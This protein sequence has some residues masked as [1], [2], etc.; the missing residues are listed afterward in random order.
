MSSASRL[1]EPR[2]IIVPT[3][4]S[5]LGNTYKRATTEAE[6]KVQEHM[7]TLMTQHLE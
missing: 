3:F 2:A 1:E 5:D 7:R 4:V 6:N